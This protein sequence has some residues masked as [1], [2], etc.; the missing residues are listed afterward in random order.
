MKMDK[1]IIHKF[2]Q[3]YVSRKK[4]KMSEFT[5]AELELDSGSNSE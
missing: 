3:K 2:I 4:K 5:D 1:K